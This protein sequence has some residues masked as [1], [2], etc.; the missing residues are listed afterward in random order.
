MAKAFRETMSKRGN[1]LKKLSPAAIQALPPRL[2]LFMKTGEAFPRTMVRLANGTKKDWP[3]AIRIYESLRLR[4]GDN[5][6]TV[7]NNLAWA[8]SESGDILPGIDHPFEFRDRT[9]MR[10]RNEAVFPRHPVALR[11]LR[12]LADDLRHYR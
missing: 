6:A 11:N 12:H 1:G 3:E 2:V 8:Y 5:D 10:K 9:D 4:L 7:L